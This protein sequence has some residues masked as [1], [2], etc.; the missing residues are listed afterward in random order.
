MKFSLATTIGVLVS[1]S[2]VLFGV[3]EI[4]GIIDLKQI[5]PFLDRYQFLNLPSL[6]I[7]LGG[8]LN[9]LFIMY[10]GRYVV[11]ALGSVYHLFTRSTIDLNTLKANIR[12]ILSWNKR[13][14]ENKVQA[15]N[16]LQ[17]EYAGKL[18]AY[19]FT[20]VSTNY[21]SEDIRE[22]S[23]TAIEEHYNRGLITVEVLDSMGGS[24]P[25][26][27]MFGTLFGLIVM[28]GDL[29]N[30]ANMGPGLATALITTLYG[31]TLA[32]LVFFP[33]AR[34]LRNLAQMSRFQEMMML[35]GVLMIKEGKS[36]MFI[37]DK[38]NAYL[39]RE[40]SFNPEETA[41]EAEKA[42]AG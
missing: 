8:V 6:F 42:T 24:S 21:S 22:L 28:L 10:P 12:E 23:E 36:P 16:S 30:P 40:C 32:Y 25:A 5:A 26:F 41:K 3:F 18:P 20:L 33:I 9:S 7:V 37:Q 34:K 17:E 14:S 31:I 27:G 1:F 29:Q 13:I 35:E 15:L 39:R 19:L 38:L 11:K 4:V 2:L